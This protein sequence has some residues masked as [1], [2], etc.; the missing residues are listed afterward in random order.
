VTIRMMTKREENETESALP[1]KIST[2]VK[3]TIEEVGVLEAE[4]QIDIKV[5][6]TTEI[7]AQ[8]T[9]LIGTTIAAIPNM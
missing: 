3:S 5:I 1:V 2:S 7:V 9:S 4:V 6:V 8:I